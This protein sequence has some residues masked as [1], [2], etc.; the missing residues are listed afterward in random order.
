MRQISTAI[1]KNRHNTLPE[2]LS[3]A[4]KYDIIG[5]ECVSKIP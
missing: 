3:G 1:N 2:L 4:E 5:L